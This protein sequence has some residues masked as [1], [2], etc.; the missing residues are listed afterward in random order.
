MILL[1]F[2]SVIRKFSPLRHSPHQPPIL[3]S[4]RC[5][6]HYSYQD[7]LQPCQPLQPALHM[8]SG[9]HFSAWTLQLCVNKSKIHIHCPGAQGSLICLHLPPVFNSL[10]PPILYLPATATSPSFAGL[11][12]PHTHSPL[13]V[14]PPPRPMETAAATHVQLRDHLLGVSCPLG[15]IASTLPFPPS[16]PP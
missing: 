13:P 5:H 4:P 16:Q 2:Q 15:P 14:D 12:A 3:P 1:S 7:S 9:G 11:L 6:Y 8:A 10:P